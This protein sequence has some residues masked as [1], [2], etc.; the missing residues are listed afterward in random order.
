M[1]NHNHL[2][3][4][5]FYKVYMLRGKME[6]MPFDLLE[7]PLPLNDDSDLSGN[8]LSDQ[9]IELLRDTSHVRDYSD[10]EWRRMLSDAGFGVLEVQSWPVRLEFQTWVERMK[11]PQ[12]NVQAIRALQK[13]APIEV[14][15]ALA[16]EPDGSFTMVTGMYWC[17]VR[18]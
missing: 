14:S 6:I 13:G 17:Q 11:T 1:Y 2:I 5:M 18:K 9:S 3:D 4:G 15:E 12:A 7:M 8:P 10:A 16:Y